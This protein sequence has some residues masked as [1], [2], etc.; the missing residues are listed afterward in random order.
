I[1]KN[2]LIC[3]WD[4][5]NAVIL[6]DID[7]VIEFSGLEEGITYKEETDEQ[8]G[9]KEKVISDSRDKNKVPVL[10]INNKKGEIQK[11]I[12]VPV[13]ARLSV[14]NGQ[15]IVAGTIM[16]KIPRTGGKTRDI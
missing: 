9:F 12:N 6:S 15:K 13:G 16:A 8:T 1:S 2:D 10:L 14:E 3:A 11:E 7:G 5:Y 4:P